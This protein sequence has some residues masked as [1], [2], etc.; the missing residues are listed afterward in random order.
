[1]KSC[2][3]F[4]PNHHWKHRSAFFVIAY[5]CSL[6]LQYWIS[7]FIW[8][9]VLKM[10]LVE[11]NVRLAVYKSLCFVVSMTAKYFG[12]WKGYATFVLSKRTFTM[13]PERFLTTYLKIIWVCAFLCQCVC[14]YSNN[15][16]GPYLHMA[17]FGT[18]FSYGRV[19]YMYFVWIWSSLDR[20]LG[21]AGL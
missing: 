10:L 20:N 12:T 3:V 19:F 8:T 18:F 17:V 11:S 2:K 5:C 21:W 13:L 7:F 9:D 14:T 1:M 6:Q 4:K 15:Y 16:M